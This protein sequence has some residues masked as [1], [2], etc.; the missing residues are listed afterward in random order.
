MARCHPW[1]SK[2]NVKLRLEAPQRVHLDTCAE[3]ARSVIWNLLRNACQYTAE[4]EI[5]LALRGT[6]LII[7]DTGPGL[8]SSIPPHQFERFKSGSH[9]NGEGLGLSI[10]QRI[11]EHLGWYMKVESSEQGCRFTLEMNPLISPVA[12]VYYLFRSRF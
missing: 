9:Q 12:A 10:V 8:P 5:Y 7:S 6:T 2:K 4:G 1:L 3:L 11:V